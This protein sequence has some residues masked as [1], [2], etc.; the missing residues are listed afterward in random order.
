MTVSLVHRLNMASTP[1][2]LRGIIGEA[3]N[4]LSTATVIEQSGPTGA[5]EPARQYS[6]I[7]AFRKQ[8]G[9]YKSGAIAGLDETIELLARAGDKNVHGGVIETDRGF[10]TVYFDDDGSIVGAMIARKVTDVS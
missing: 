9:Y 4:L 1:P 2:P 3:L 8:S 5:G 7:H 10:I 6:D